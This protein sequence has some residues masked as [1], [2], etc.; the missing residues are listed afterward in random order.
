MGWLGQPYVDRLVRVVEAAREGATPSQRLGRCAAALGRALEASVVALTLLSGLDAE[1]Q[2]PP[3]VG[4][5]LAVS[6]PPDPCPG[7][8]APDARRPRPWSVLG[9]ELGVAGST[10]LAWSLQRDPRRPPFLRRDRRAV[11]LVLPYVAAGVGA[12]MGAEPSPPSEQESPV[13]VL[14]GGGAIARAN[15]AARLLLPTLPEDEARRLSECAV[16]AVPTFHA[17]VL[18]P[19]PGT[20]LRASLV[21]CGAARRTVAVLHH[22]EPGSP[23]V[24]EEVRRRTGLTPRQA[25]VLQM[26][27]EGLSVKEVATALRV[28]S[29]TIKTVIKRAAVK[30]GV[31]GRVQLTRVLRGELDP[32]N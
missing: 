23:A 14:D 19:S 31:R 5:W 13:L 18:H 6:T 32:P 30:L 20:W 12:L 17:A 26:L 28:R 8:A 7:R 1:E 4:E 22:L 15:E 27:G 2:R 3:A 16:A 24:V 21:R 9:G 29:E 25:E 10:H 11:D